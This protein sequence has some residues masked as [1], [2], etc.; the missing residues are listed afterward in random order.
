MAVLVTLVVQNSAQAIF[1]RYS[2]KPKVEVEGQ[3]MEAEPASS[4]AVVM[5]ELCKLLCSLILQYRVRAEC[6]LTPT[7][8]ESYTADV[9]L[10]L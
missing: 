2:F 4:T 5:A 10:L 7:S 3:E 9:V 6:E 8:Y 1:M